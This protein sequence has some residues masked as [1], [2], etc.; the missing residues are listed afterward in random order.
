M[1][2][3][4][5]ASTIMVALLSGAATG[6]VEHGLAIRLT[7]QVSGGAVDGIVVQETF[8]VEALPAGATLVSLPMVSQSVPGVLDDPA[9]LVASDPSG[10]LPL[11]MVEDPVDPSGIKQDRHWRTSRATGG[12]IT[13][14]YMA[15]PRA[16]TPETKPAALIDMRTEGQGVYGS[17]QMLLALPEG[18]WPR[19]VTIDWDLAAMVPGSRAVTSFGEGSSTTTLDADTL[20]YGYFMAGPWQKL[21]P[22]ADR[23]F[24]VYYLTPPAFDLDAAAQDVAATYRYATRFFGT[25]PQPFRALMRTTQRFQGGGGGGRNSFIFG[26]VK[27]EGREPDEINALLTHEALHNWIN[28]MKKGPQ[29]AWFDEGATNYYTAIL[30]YRIGRRSIV[31]VEAQIGEWTSN[32]YGNARRTMGED[33]ARAAFW[34]D[35]DAQMLPYSRGPLYIALVDARLRAISGGRKRVDPL[36]R[37]MVH[38]IRDG[39][40]SEDMWLALVSQALGER[41]RQDFADL[42]AGRMLDLP[43]DLFGPCFRRE[44]GPVRRYSPGFRI[45]TGA[46]GRRTAGPVRPGSPAAT[47]GLTRG[48]EILNWADLDGAARQPGASVSLRIRQAGTVRDI[49]LEPWGPARDGFRWVASTPRPAVCNL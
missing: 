48:D 36:V 5:A 39:T 24:M 19:K 40:A 28:A 42:K 7:P 26:T 25:A 46:D 2:R 11:A 6:P 9:T 20:A 10:P 8:D 4:T 35:A 27:G 17:T 45:E 33:A 31:Q 14:T 37:T 32:Y 12:R 38:A 29:G 3:R 13:V 49:H 44:A 15:R 1:I 43:A 18:G 47:A 22:T 34:T 41:G 21:P 16:I 23:G 30:P